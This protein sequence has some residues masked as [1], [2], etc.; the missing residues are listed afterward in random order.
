MAVWVILMSCMTS[1]GFL[2]IQHFRN[3]TNFAYFS[4]KSTKFARFLIMNESVKYWYFWNQRGIMYSKAL[5]D[6]EY[7]RVVDS[8]KGSGLSLTTKSTTSSSRPYKVRIWSVAPLS[9]MHKG[10]VN[11]NA[12]FTAQSAFLRITIVIWSKNEAEIRSES[13]IA[14]HLMNWA[15]CVYLIH[16]IILK[17]AL[18]KWV[19]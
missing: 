9:T 15:N 10:N 12:S 19:S 18:P 8:W 6:I 17:S 3:R 13:R 2:R 16:T 11:T 5:T 14:L 1:V 4:R 7:V